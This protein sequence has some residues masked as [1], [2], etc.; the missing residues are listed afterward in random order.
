MSK[1]FTVLRSDS[2]LADLSPKIQALFD[3]KYSAIVARKEEQEEEEEEST[4]EL[5]ETM[6]E[7][8]ISNTESIQRI[9][10]EKGLSLPE[11]ESQ[12]ESLEKLT[13]SLEQSSGIPMKL[14]KSG[15]RKRLVK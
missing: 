5:I 2:R 11:E 15:R 14:V 1:K 7:A 9:L 13:K 6:L 10:E 12:E 8:I 3:K 4:Q